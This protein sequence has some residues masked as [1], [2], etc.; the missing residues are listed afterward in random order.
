MILRFSPEEIQADAHELEL[1]SEQLVGEDRLFLAVQYFDVLEVREPGA[2]TAW[3]RGV[4]MLERDSGTMLAEDDEPHAYR[5]KVDPDIAYSTA[6]Q[7][8]QHVYS[9][10]V[11]PK[12]H[13]QY[14]EEC[15]VYGN[16]PR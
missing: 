5:C 7:V 16:K 12:P 8:R 4:L 11:S 10:L 14:S 6:A 13:L 15:Y 9:V 1:V 3:A 2:P